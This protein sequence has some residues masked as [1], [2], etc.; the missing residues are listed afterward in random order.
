M[1]KFKEIAIQMADLIALVNTNQARM[2]LLAEFT[3]TT[4]YYKSLS[5]VF[6][7]TEDDAESFGFVICHRGPQSD[8]FE[9][10]FFVLLEDA[11]DFYD[12]LPGD[13][14]AKYCVDYYAE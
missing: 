5:E 2:D 7:P 12:A 11:L 13:T 14:Y 6:D 9:Q 3:N 10:E 4:F 1:G 8:Q